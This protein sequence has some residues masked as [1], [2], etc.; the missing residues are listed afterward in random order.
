ML[1]HQIIVV[2]RRLAGKSSEMPVH[3]EGGI[4]LQLVLSLLKYI[5]ERRKLS[6]RL[7]VVFHNCLFK[8]ILL[9]LLFLKAELHISEVLGVK[10]PALSELKLT[11]LPGLSP[12]RP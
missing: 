12:Q 5:V 10:P 6:S 2:T 8:S 3:V 11:L 4:L 9:M 1:H 7:I